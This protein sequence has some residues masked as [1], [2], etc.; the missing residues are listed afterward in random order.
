[1]NDSGSE[2][3]H[4]IRINASVMELSHNCDT[5]DYLMERLSMETTLVWLVF[6][7]TGKLNLY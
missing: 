4:S 1:M 3:I 6:H 2:Y 5:V 7:A